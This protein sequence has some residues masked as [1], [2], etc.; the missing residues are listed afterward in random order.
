[1]TTVRA[2]GTAELHESAPPADEVE[3]YVKKYREGIARIGFDVDDFA[4][5]YTVAGRVTPTRRQ[6]W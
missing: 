6:V 5:A 1:M 2:E 4:Q 3:A